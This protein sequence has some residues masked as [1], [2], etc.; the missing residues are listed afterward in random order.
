MKNKKT[1]IMLAANEN[2]ATF[3]ANVIIGLKRY[4]KNVVER[5]IVFHDLEDETM[6]KI[7]SIWP[8]K[9]K[10]IKYGLD[11]F[12]VDFG[13][14]TDIPLQRFS[15]LIYAKFYIF[16]IV[17]DYEQVIWLDS[18]V[19][20]WDKIDNLLLDSDVEVMARK[21]YL[22]TAK[23]LMERYYKIMN[24]S[25]HIP[26]D[27]I[28]I[29]EGVVALNSS[30]L[31]R[32]S[33]NDLTKECFTILQNLYKY[34]IVNGN[35]T[36]TDFIP[37]NVV[38]IKHSLKSKGW[39]GLADTWQ[40][41]YGS[42]S[43]IIHM[44]GG[45]K[46]W[47]SPFDFFS[48]QEWH[49]N[50]KIWTKI[51]HGSDTLKLNKINVKLETNQ[52][53]FMLIRRIDALYP[54]LNEINIVVDKFNKYRFSVEILPDYSGILIKSYYT[55]I[56]EFK[57]E[58]IVFPWIVNV[59]N[60][61]IYNINDNSLDIKLKNYISLILSKNIGCNTFNHD[62]KFIVAKQ[63]SVNDTINNLIEIIN[64]NSEILD[65]F[66][67]NNQANYKN[68]LSYKLGQALIVAHKN[69]YK[70][71]YI[72]FIFDSLKIVNSHKK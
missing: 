20:V 1:A 56:I 14:D 63:T 31:N 67:K 2:Y 33:N 68:Y 53:L 40:H 45:G 23:P 27:H 60:S 21:G 52:D 66:V 28:F 49:V 35:G 32:I 44:S 13:M 11:E 69:W 7:N 46:P 9:L 37:L 34:K 70:G 57:I 8:N 10:F 41:E 26:N 36:G 48:Y 24:E 50:H 43:S 29:K 15:H 62:N 30:I 55:K 12:R 54:I 16:N 58:M 72:K 18:D 22:G 59:K 61:L 47:K 4:S 6:K 25:C 17:K 19:L 39:D 5:I 65:I 51:Y 38:V 64:A 42:K 3:L 71:G